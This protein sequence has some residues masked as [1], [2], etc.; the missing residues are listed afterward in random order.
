[1]L[2]KTLHI[3]E[4]TAVSQLAR[5]TL[6]SLHQQR[7]SSARHTSPSAIP[8]TAVNC[9]HPGFAPWPRC[10]THQAAASSRSP[11]PSSPSTAM[12]QGATWCPQGLTSCADTSTCGCC[13]CRRRHQEQSCCTIS[14]LG[15]LQFCSYRSNSS[16][17]QHF[18]QQMQQFKQNGAKTSAIDENSCSSSK[19]ST[20]QGGGV[21][22]E[23]QLWQLKRHTAR[24]E[25]QQPRKVC[26]GRVGTMIAAFFH[27][28]AYAGRWL[29]IPRPPPPPGGSLTCSSLGLL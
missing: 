16:R 8:V 25:Q 3:R 27:K 19:L 1:M 7:A 12:L 9:L 22:G 4:M 6:L 13:S 26:W 2:S 24:H 10:P 14:K 11:Q 17:S 5:A 18:L 21:E 28:A 20:G 29:L 15:T 23:K